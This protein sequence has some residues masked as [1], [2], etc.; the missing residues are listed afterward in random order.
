MYFLTEQRKAY[1]L[2]KVKAENRSPLNTLVCGDS[3][4]NA[5]LVVVAGVHGVMI[6]FNS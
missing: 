3:G 5:E 2:K 1:L 4:N 6:S